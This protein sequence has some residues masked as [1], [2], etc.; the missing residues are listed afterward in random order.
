M[1][2]MI[3]V[4]AKIMED[5][6]DRIANAL[7]SFAATWNGLEIA[8]Q[9]RNGRAQLDKIK[10]IMEFKMPYKTIYSIFDYEPVNETDEK[11]V[12]EIK[13]SLRENGWQGPPIIVANGR[14]VTGSHR[15]QACRELDLEDAC[16]EEIYQEENVYDAS[17]IMDAYFAAHPDKEMEYIGLE[18]YFAG[19][20]VEQ[21]LIGTKEW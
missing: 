11:R 7:E 17:E 6:T 13:A 12:E 15:L 10:K 9:A 4:L 2:N 21:F 20:Y 16:F 3:D 14:L 8:K 19:T 18:E 5:E 1:K